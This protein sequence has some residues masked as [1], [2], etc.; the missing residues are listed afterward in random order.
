VG[1]YG[2]KDTGSRRRVRRPY[3]EWL[4]GAVADDALEDACGEQIEW[5]LA[6]P[7]MFRALNSP[8]T[9]EEMLSA[10]RGA[11]PAENATALGY[12]TPLLTMLIYTFGWPRPDR[13]LRWWYKAGKPLDD[14]RLRLMAQVWD[15]DGQ[16]DW[17]AGW[18]W[19]RQHLELSQQV[20]ELT[21]Y[22][23]DGVAVDVPQR[24]IQATRADADAAGG[25]APLGS[26][27]SDPLHLSFHC[28]G[29][30]RQR[31]QGG[32]LLHSDASERRAVLLLEGMVGWY[33]A[34]VE[35]GRSLP[36]LGDRSWHVD[37]V[38]R[39]VGTLGTFR[40]SKVTGLWFSGPH[41][42][43]IVGV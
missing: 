18:L 14:P 10:P 30:L 2:L 9:H 24:W 38:V 34:L 27:S 7:W 3:P 22:R 17:F 20:S 29:P 26:G 6:I 36:D 1:N 8:L 4:K 13:G 42:L 39:P 12:W 43:H 37:V 32:L 40:R 35:H 23:D 15:A 11:G 5:G 31:R 19:T 28:H 25:N 41:R 16:L 21:G 33:R